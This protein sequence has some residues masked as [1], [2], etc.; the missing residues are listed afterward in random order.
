[1][2]ATFTG[3]V[4]LSVW[5][6]GVAR[7]MN[8]L[9]A[10]SRPEVFAAPEAAADKQVREKYGK[11]LDLLE[12]D[13]SIDVLSGTSA[14]GINAALLGAA[15]VR[16]RDLGMLR[17]LWLEQGALDLLLRDPSES[18]PPSLLLGDDVLLDGLREALAELVGDAEPR[19][20]A[21]EDPTRVFIT[22]TLLDGEEITFTDDYGTAIHDTAH[23]G[24]FSFTAEQLDSPGVVDALALAARSSASF[25]GAFEPAFVPVGEPGTDEHPDMAPHVG[26]GLRT[27]FCADGGLLA[28]RP[29][30]PALEAVFERGASSEVRR[31]LA[32]VVPFPGKA[33]ETPVRLQEDVPALGAALLADVAAVRS[34]SITSELKAVLAHNAQARSRENSESR[35]AALAGARGDLGAGGLLTEYR[36]LHARG[37]AR[38][39]ANETLRQLVATR[40]RA[41]DGRPAGFGTDLED[42]TEAAASLIKEELPTAPAGDGALFG[43]LARF[44]RPAF[45][46]AKATVLRLL[47]GGFDATRSDPTARVA[48][49][50]F[51]EQAHA[52]AGHAASVPA[53]PRLSRDLIASLPGSGPLPMDSVARL[54]GSDAWQQAV[55]SLVPAA[56]ARTG[57]ST[58]WEQLATVVAEARELLRNLL[59]SDDGDPLGAVLTHLSGP[60]PEGTPR[61]AA[62]RHVARRL[63]DLQAA[64]QVMYPQEPAARQI[65]ELVQMSAETRT[66]LDPR[67]LPSEKLTG[68]QVH[69][70]G[71]FYK[72]SWRAN[73]WMWGRLDGAGWLVHLLLS[74]R[75]LAQLAPSGEKERAAFLEHLTAGLQ[76]IV[77]EPVPAEVADELEG[78]ASNSTP[79][80]ATLKASRWVAK[81][82]Q[83][84][85]A[86]EELGFVARQA[87][88]DR[89]RDHASGEELE[90]FLD[91][92][93]AADPA[94]RDPA[95]VLATAQRLLH[96]C[97][98]SRET[99]DGEMHTTPMRLTVTR[100][101]AVAA[102]AVRAGVGGRWRVIAPVFGS[103]GG[104]LRVTHQGQR[105]YEHGANWFGAQRGR[106]S[107]VFTSLRGT[108]A[109]AVRH[110][111]TA[112]LLEGRGDGAKGRD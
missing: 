39:A 2:A 20:G 59:S 96:A 70:F 94:P 107:S 9:A 84:R 87:V 54:T 110:I 66:D 37:L 11:L 49:G 16:H 29:L 50:G 64:Q 3:G 17:D 43:E 33:E 109:T 106:L 72:S 77:G 48:L 79:P 108:S 88:Q 4:S 42:L 90:T 93:G 62:V 111:G 44:G 82:L 100:A 104:I 73:D 18:A 103:V 60:E 31:V 101:A 12:L 78:V 13:F 56:S 26:P 85:I 102:N 74:P 95:A 55:R 23:R 105:L 58:A 45:D 81:G 8:L 41:A 61:D 65:V 27:Q 98:V 57:L 80:P 86:L 71:A 10:A 53:K 69:N 92:Q 97:Q 51:V 7:E 32:Y 28:N 63:F 75:R 14:G 19:I 35:L 36:D 5:M 21:D 76:E 38:T 24:L 40:R 91:M 34:Q 46:G 52:A 112:G 89:D 99:F 1:M 68:R 47:R 15:N 22:T 25:P 67:S 83:A 30:G 6:G